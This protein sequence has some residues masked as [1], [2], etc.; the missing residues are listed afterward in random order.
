MRRHPTHMPLVR[1]CPAAARVDTRATPMGIA[2]SPPH[3]LHP[4]PA[5]P[6]RRAARHASHRA[7]T[8]ERCHRCLRRFACVWGLQAT[9]N[10]LNSWLA[11]KQYCRPWGDFEVSGPVARASV[12]EIMQ[13]CDPRY[14]CYV[15]CDVNTDMCD[16]GAECEQPGVTY[17]YALYWSVMT[18]TSVG[19]GDIYATPFNVEEQIVCTVMMLLGGMLW[20]YLIGTFCGIAAQMSPGVREFRDNLSGLN[21]FMTNHNLPDMMRVK[22]REYMHQSVHLMAARRDH[23]VLRYLSRQMQLEVAW[24]VHRVWLERVWYLNVNVLNQRDVLLDLAS[25]LKAGVYPPGELCKPGYMYI[26]SRGLALRGGRVYRSGSVWGED[27]LLAHDHLQK[28]WC[29]AHAQRSAQR[30]RARATRV[31]H[32][33]FCSL[34]LSPAAHA[35]TRAPQAGAGD[36]LL[37]GLH[38]RLGDTPQRPRASRQCVA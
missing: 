29:A 36:E 21:A 26:V 20:G 33:S 18:V 15:E 37:V 8:S 27:I 7:L 23:D 5:V 12:D 1:A 35:R 11:V 28:N 30:A 6:V 17:F 9:F 2:A 24:F 13:T 4:P 10:R 25:H 14:R 3:L 22:L 16:S 32:A 38:P 34:T 31:E 19:F